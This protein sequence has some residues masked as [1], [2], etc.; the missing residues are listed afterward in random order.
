ME[1]KSKF[2]FEIIQKNENSHNIN[3]DSYRLYKKINNQ[4]RMI[5]L[6]KRSKILLELRK[7]FDLNSFVETET[8]LLVKSPSPEEQFYLY[9]V[10][11]ENKNKFKKKENY[12]LITSPE[13]QMKRLL[14]GGFK[15]IFQICKCFRGN[16]KG[17]FH[18]TEFTMLEWYRAHS[19]LEDL[20]RDVESFCYFLSEKEFCI[21]S[22]PKG[23]WKKYKV[24]EIFKKFLKIELDG[25]ETTQTLIDKSVI[26][27][28]ENIIKD[29]ISSGGKQHVTYDDIFFRLWNSI[30]SQLGS[31]KPIWV[32][33]W[34]L[35]LASLARPIENNPLFADRVECYY[36]GI[37]L[38][39]GFGELT[40]KNEQ[41]KRFQNNLSNRK[42]LNR[43]SVPLD[44]KFLSSLDDGLSPCSGMALGLD[45]LLLFL[46]G[47]K[48]IDEIVCFSWNEL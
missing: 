12:F 3:S 27:G 21:S 38:A 39:N 20:I 28:F 9:K 11:L 31:D 40:D 25:C 33:E 30:E 17:D 26:A 45:R 2:K 42:R 44:K 41:L 1:D 22:F 36:K 14:V 16:E 43:P 7:W 29:L 4:F 24:K 32:Y 34:P 15:K 35:P 19:N 37:E 5:I 47:V 48:K 13:F 6:Y 23:P 18:M 46:L 8:P 10:F